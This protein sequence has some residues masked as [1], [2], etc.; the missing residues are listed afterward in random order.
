MKDRKWQGMTVEWYGPSFTIKNGVLSSV[1]LHEVTEF[2]V[3]DGV[4]SIGDYAFD[5][6]ECR[7]L[8]SVTIPNSVTNIGIQAFAW[9]SGLKSVTIPDGVTSIGNRAFEYCS[10]LTSVTIPDAVR[11]I[12][13]SAF[14]GCSG[15]TSVTIGN[16]VT[17]IG[18]YAFY[19]CR[20][21]TSVTIPNSVTNIGFD[22]FY[23]CTNLTSVTMKG[24]AP[25]VGGD[26]FSNIGENAVVRLPVGAS[27]YNFDEN[28]QW[29]RMS[30]VWYAFGAEVTVNGA[31]EA[32]TD[33]GDGKS[34][35]A[36]VAEGTV[37]E[38]IV[39][40]VEGVDVSK[41]YSRKVEGTT[42][43]IALLNPYEVP[44][45]AGTPDAP[46]TE[47][48]KG[49]VTLNVEVVPGLYYAAASAASLGELKCPGA[50]APAT[51]GTT[52]TVAKP[53]SETQGFFRVWVSDRAI[54]AE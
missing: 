18:G 49:N 22:A 43:T 6:K 54:E 25:S 51:A 36:S 23:S 41:G 38:D 50:A 12:G 24:D 40:K 30:V 16:G 5:G 48:G 34:M 8:M 28:G 7:G 47:D 10:S 17:S 21:L 39:V 26:A 9:C 42:A 32:F 45:E 53:D 19:S 3:P 20:G 31:A 29:M 2:V 13:Q 52:L 46:W 27:G 1:Y 14:Y 35:T 44:K 37:A 11:S 33:A 4:T 15:L